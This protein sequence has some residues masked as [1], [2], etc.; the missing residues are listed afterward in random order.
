MK[1]C[2][3]SRAVNRARARHSSACWNQ[4]GGAGAHRVFWSFSCAAGARQ[5]HLLPACLCCCRA[6]STG[7]GAGM[8]VRQALCLG[9]RRRPCRVPGTAPC[10]PAKP[11]ALL[12]AHAVCLVPLLHRCLAPAQILLCLPWDAHGCCSRRQGAAACTTLQGRVWAG[13]PA[14]CLGLGTGLTS[15]P[16]PWLLLCFRHYWPRRGP[17]ATCSLIFWPGAACEGCLQPAKAH[18]AGLLL[19]LACLGPRLGAER[20]STRAAPGLSKL[21]KGEQPGGWMHRAASGLIPKSPPQA[22][23]QPLIL[24]LPI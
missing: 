16:G 23:G 8:G 7:T 19:A 21:G 1:L 14:A 9:T 18:R 24:L 5:V 6:K 4:F 13:C 3:T 2:C 12:A 15:S 22:T 17:S 11:S 10:P 20:L